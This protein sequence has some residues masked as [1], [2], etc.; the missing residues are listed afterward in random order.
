ML[1]GSNI[2]STHHRSRFDSARRSEEANTF[3]GDVIPTL[4][5][6]GRSAGGKHRCAGGYPTQSGLESS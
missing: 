2:P 5:A 1:L 3:P 6:A 4:N